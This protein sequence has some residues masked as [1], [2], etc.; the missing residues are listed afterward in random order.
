MG[1]EE[2]ERGDDE[3]DAGVRGSRARTHEEDEQERY[4]QRARDV[5]G[6]QDQEAGGAPPHGEDRARA[7]E[8][9]LMTD[10]RRAQGHAAEED[11]T[12]AR[13]DERGQVSEPVGVDAPDD[14]AGDLRGRR[15]DD[16][17]R[18]LRS[19]RA[20]EGTAGRD[21][22]R[23]RERAEDALAAEADLRVGCKESRQ[24][25]GA[26]GGIPARH[27][28]PGHIAPGCRGSQR[29]VCELGHG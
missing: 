1:P 22:E 3:E 19:P 23:P 16:D 6:G 7:H 17:D 11:D 24:V 25:E 18:D 13:R 20:R 8:R 15:G 4:A 21:E 29:A 14:R 5:P 10:E 26:R 2:L 27:M 12:V 9:S 28:A